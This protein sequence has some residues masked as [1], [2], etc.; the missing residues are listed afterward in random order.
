MIKVENISDLS[1]KDVIIFMLPD[2][3][4]VSKSANELVKSNT[5][6]LLDSFKPL[7]TKQN[8]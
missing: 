8:G 3:K 5:N 6:W 2:G 4:E 1:D 7:F